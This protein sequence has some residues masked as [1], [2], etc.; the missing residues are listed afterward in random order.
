[1]FTRESKTVI[2]L[3]GLSHFAVHS[4]MLFFPALFIVL[5]EEFSAEAITLATLSWI[6]TLSNFMFG[7]GALPA[8]WIEGKVGGRK[9]LLLYQL[10]AAA[11]ALFVSISTS[12]TTLTIALV[13]LGLFSSIYHPAGL[14]IISRRIHQTSRAMG[15]HGIAG[16]AGLAAGPLL[17]SLSAVAGSWRWAYVGIGLFCLLLAG[18]TATFIPSR[19]SEAAK[20]RRSV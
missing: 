13:F 2:T 18:A 10:G 20:P 5:Q 6:Y 16:S 3:T 12:L 8:G 19:K 14:T 17:A 15:Y 4:S 7:F 1:M 11:S 9:L